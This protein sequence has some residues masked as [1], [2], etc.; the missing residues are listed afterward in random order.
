MTFS[1]FSANSEG[2]K[3][4]SSR[5]QCAISSALSG[6]RILMG[7]SLSNRRF[8][9]GFLRRLKEW[10]SAYRPQSLTI[11]L[12]D[13]CEAINYQV[14]RGDPEL[15]AESTSKR[16]SIEMIRGFMRPF[17]DA[18]FTTRFCLE[19]DFHSKYQA[20]IDYVYSMILIAYER[21]RT[22]HRDVNAQ[23][24]INL[25]SRL[26]AAK[27]KTGSSASVPEGAARYVLRELAVFHVLFRDGGFEA[28]IYP[29][30]QLFVKQAL[31][32]GK[33]TSLKALCLP[34]G[35]PDFVEVSFLCSP[36]INR[37]L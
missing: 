29:G 21:D 3:T 35:C 22:F 9:K 1:V 6:K 20:E 8:T 2:T 37:A 19:S 5:D 28:E 12:F 4:I 15:I 26:A 32:E 7:V 23:I 14:F 30:D 31:W 17:I 27:A 33:Y 36:D 16:R 10:L 34:K 25:A 24:A 18:S 11:T 13:E